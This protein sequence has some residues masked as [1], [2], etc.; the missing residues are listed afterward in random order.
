MNVAGDILNAGGNV[1]YQEDY[2]FTQS[3]FKISPIVIYD[4]TKRKLT[5]MKI[6]PMLNNNEQKLNHPPCEYIDE[7]EKDKENN[8][9]SEEDITEQ[10]REDKK[11]K[12]G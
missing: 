10:A 4:T 2:G 7:I 5:K 1:E 9:T 12:K 11:N 8:L 6:T 3:F